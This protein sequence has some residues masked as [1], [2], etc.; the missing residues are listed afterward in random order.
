MAHPAGVEPAT[1]A[2]GG[3][4]KQILLKGIS[5]IASFTAPDFSGAGVGYADVLRSVERRRA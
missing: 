2:F 5:A 1:F 4:R 3:L